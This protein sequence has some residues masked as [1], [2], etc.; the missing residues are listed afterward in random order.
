MTYFN[1]S[2]LKAPKFLVTT[3]T[4]AQITTSS[5]NTYETIVGSEISYVP[6]ANSSNVVYEI[7]FYSQ[8]TQNGGVLFQ[9]LD[10]EEST[11]GG[12]SWSIINA[13][14]KKNYGNSGSSSQEN[15]YYIHYRYVLS[16]WSG[17]KHLRLRTATHSSSV[18]RAV[19][20]HQ[21]TEWDGASAT[22]QF[23]NTNLLIYS[24]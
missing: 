16:S 3:H 19:E 22:D 15:R 5:V 1:Q 20:L 10:L 11:D 7:S 24:I 21:L 13:K 2:A 14:F 12:S 18:N 6:F 23:C 4:S 17:E 8:K 9:I